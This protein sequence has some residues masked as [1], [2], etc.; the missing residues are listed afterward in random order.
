MCLQNVAGQENDTTTMR[1]GQEDDTTTMLP[2]TTTAVTGD[3]QTHYSI[4]SVVG[5]SRMP[6]ASVPIFL[7]LLLLKNGNKSSTVIT[8]LGTR[9]R[10]ITF[11]D[12]SAC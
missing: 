8:I 10:N 5:W 11:H 12:A 1:A 3:D 9:N 4:V 2:P 7:L 6:L